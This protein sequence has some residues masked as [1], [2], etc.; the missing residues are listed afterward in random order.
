MLICGYRY[1][2][3]GGWLVFEKLLKS[4]VALYRATDLRVWQLHLLWEGIIFLKDLH[5]FVQLLCTFWKGDRISGQSGVHCSRS[6]K[7]SWKIECTSLE[8]GR[9]ELN[10]RCPCRRLNADLFVEAN[11]EG[12]LWVR[13][14]LQGFNFLVFGYLS[15]ICSSIDDGGAYD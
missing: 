2:L 4:I 1:P 11:G 15:V 5:V 12:F 3:D 9:L 13:G 6:E 7:S 14:S 8:R 10:S